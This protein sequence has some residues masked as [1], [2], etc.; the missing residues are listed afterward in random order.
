MGLQI[1]RP[2]NLDMGTFCDSQRLAF[3]GD[4]AGRVFQGGPVQT[5]RAFLLHA[6]DHSGPETEK[7][8]SNIR[9]S[10]SLE[11]LRILVETPPKDMR[12][13]LGYAGWGPGQLAEEVAQGTWLVT[14]PNPQLVFEKKPEQIWELALREMGID[15]VQLMHSGAVH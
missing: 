7:V 9:L 1:N 4:N 2:S 8:I 11:S 3:K 15:P 5:D 10:Y 13:Y 12:V 6:S 14:Q